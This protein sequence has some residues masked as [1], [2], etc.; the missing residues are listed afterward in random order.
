M[1]DEYREDPKALENFER[2]IENFER[3]IKALLQVKT[4]DS[5][6]AL[7]PKSKRRTASK[8]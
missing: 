8:D 7:K 4:F 5:K 6:E 3:N 1:K 2:T